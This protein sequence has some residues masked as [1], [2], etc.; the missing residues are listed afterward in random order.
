MERDVIE[1]LLGLSWWTRVLN[2]SNAD[3]VQSEVIQKALT[4]Q[5][6]LFQKFLNADNTLQGQAKV[7]NDYL[8]AKL[9]VVKGQHANA[10]TY[11]KEQI[12]S[13]YLLARIMGNAGNVPQ[14]VDVQL[15]VY[16]KGKSLGKGGF[17]CCEQGDMVGEKMC[18]ENHECS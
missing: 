17:W 14:E 18:F 6:K 16:T 3:M 9:K 4:K 8:C 15:K 5:E 11:N 1:I 7:D 10:D 13:I 2:M 12:L